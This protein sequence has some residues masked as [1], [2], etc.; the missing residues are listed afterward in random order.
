VKNLDAKKTIKK[1]S[2]HES[3]LYKGHVVRPGQTVSASSRYFSVVRVWGHHITLEPLSVI[4]VSEPALAIPIIVQ[5][6]VA[7]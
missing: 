4:E 1:R 2:I 5:S 3:Y 7:Q 6:E